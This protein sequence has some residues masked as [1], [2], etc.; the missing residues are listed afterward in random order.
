M[1]ISRRAFVVSA[2]LAGLAAVCRSHARAPSLEI[3]EMP[4]EP[5]VLRVNVPD[6]SGEYFTLWLPEVIWRDLPDRK[7]LAR[8]QSF[9]A[10]FKANAVFYMQTPDVKKVPWKRNAE[11]GLVRSVDFPG[12][13]ILCSAN[14][15]D[16]E[17]LLE[18]A[19]ANTTSQ[20]WLSSFA[21]VCLRLAPSPSFADTKRERT[22]GRIHG[23]WTRLSSTP[24]AKP[25]PARNLYLATPGNPFNARCVR[26]WWCKEFPVRLDHPLL[27]VHDRE[28]RAVVGILFDP[29]S[30]YCNCLNKEMACIHSDPF[31]GN[32]QPGGKKKSRGKLIYFKG[33]M[34]DFLKGAS[35]ISVNQ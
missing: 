11:G 23:K 7:E 32:I 12:G 18:I 20:T 8:P 22:F 6:W 33:P 3:E 9:E 27:A 31:L 30:G 13:N 2:P 28:D 15:R 24:P 19:I 35:A 10:S 14:P 4:H 25:D 29:C 26:D 16:N 34:R 17:I 21:E 1:M 5:D